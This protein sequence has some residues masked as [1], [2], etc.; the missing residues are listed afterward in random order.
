MINNL[1]IKLTEFQRGVFSRK[2]FEKDELIEICPLILIPKEQEI[3]LDKTEL[4]NYYFSINEQTNGIALGYGSLY[5]HS[6]NPNAKYI[7]SEP[8]NNIIFQALTDIHPGHEITVNYNGNPE[9]KSPLW[10]HEK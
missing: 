8:N 4:Y 1:E 6:Y 3:Y 2:H 9:D 5:N 7:K 10:F